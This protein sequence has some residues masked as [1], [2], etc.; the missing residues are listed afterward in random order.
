MWAETYPL[1][2]VSLI[3]V[4]FIL[5]EWHHHWSLSHDMLKKK[6]SERLVTA[7]CPLIIRSFPVIFKLGRAGVWSTP[8]CFILLCTLYLTRQQSGS[9]C[10]SMLPFIFCIRSVLQSSCGLSVHSAVA[11]EHCGAAISPSAVFDIVANRP[12]PLLPTLLSVSYH[13]GTRSKYFLI[14]M[15]WSYPT[16]VSLSSWPEARSAVI[17]CRMETR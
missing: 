8:K 1:S 4:A 12:S 11:R 13:G 17:C 16:L 14:Q 5:V 2:T 6:K 7:Y 15:Y 10:K 3:P 9:N